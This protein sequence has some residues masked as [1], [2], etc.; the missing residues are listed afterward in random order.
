MVEEF[1]GRITKKRELIE[2]TKTK[3]KEFALRDTMII[4]DRCKQDLAPLK[5]F[6]FINADLH[7]AKCVFG[8]FR[9][10]EVEDALQSTDY[11]QDRDFCKLYSE[12]HED[13]LNEGG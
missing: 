5:T 7:H 1:R 4:C 13:E 3:C 12:M 9:R 2:K 8:S 10:V 11:E 6:D